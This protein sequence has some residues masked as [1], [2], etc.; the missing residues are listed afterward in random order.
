MY[1]LKQA[2]RLAYDAL[3]TNLKRNGYAPDKYCPNIW[4][5]ETRQTTFCLCI[6]DF[7]VKYFNQ[8]DDEHLITSLRE[9]YE[10]T[11]DWTGSHFCGLN[12]DWTYKQGWVNISMIDYVILALHK[13]QHTFPRRPQLFPHEWTESIY[14]QK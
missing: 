2:V 5:H 14:G 10:I 11:T 4:T 6:D 8:A 1:G 7:G 9:N 13:L 12:I 3:V